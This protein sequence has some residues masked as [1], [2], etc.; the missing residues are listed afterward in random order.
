MSVFGAISDI[1]VDVHHNQAWFSYE[2]IK[3]HLH[4]SIIEV[5]Q[6]LLSFEQFNAAMEQ[7]EATVAS[8]ESMNGMVDEQVMSI[9]NHDNQLG[10]LF[11]VYFPESLRFEMADGDNA[12][13]T[14][15]ATQSTGNAADAKPAAT[16]EEQKQAGQTL[17]DKAKE[18]AK[19]MWEMLKGFFAKI[20]Q[21]LKS[22]WQWLLNGF[23]SNKASNE[24]LLAAINADTDGS[25]L[26]NALQQAQGYI[27]FGEAQASMDTS[28][29]I[30][31]APFVKA[32]GNSNCGQVMEGFDKESIW[33]STIDKL[34]GIPEDSLKKSWL[35]VTAAGEGGLLPTIE[36]DK[37]AIKNLKTNKAALSTKEWQF[38]HPAEQL[39]T[40]IKS[41]NTYYDQVAAFKPPQFI[42]LASKY[43]WEGSDY[44]KTA[45][46]NA[47][48]KKKCQAV[49]KFYT[50]WNKVVLACTDTVQAHL[51]A[52]KKYM[53]VDSGGQKTAQP[54]VNGGAGKT[55]DASDAAAAQQNKI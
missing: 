55:A 35:K 17:T 40:L 5:D 2:D 14:G 33:N 54:D 44:G 47:M 8:I 45:K 27:T 4:D 29:N 3:L 15:N 25:K 53:N 28:T 23:M 26:T 22:F 21:G 10:K 49:A 12:G 50:Q 9:V 43:D 20:A 39:V 51:N 18:V 34:L 31:N 11:G 38:V 16:T 6:A 36:M 13:Q 41:L 42:E 24:K 37:E 48:T 1:Q 7:L 19:K 30:L 46:D 52:I 32:L